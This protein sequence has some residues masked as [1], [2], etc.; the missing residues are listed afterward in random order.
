MRRWYVTLLLLSWWCFDNQIAAFAPLAPLRVIRRSSVPRRSSES[1]ATP[2]SPSEEWNVR[3]VYDDIHKLRQRIAQDRA[4]DNLREIERLELL[5]NFAANRRPLFS[6][7]RRFIL[8]PILAAV[9]MTGLSMQSTEFARLHRLVRSVFRVEFWMVVVAAPIALSRVEN[10]TPM[11]SFNST[12]TGEEVDAS[13]QLRQAQLLYST[14]INVDE[15][16]E[17]SITETC[18]CLVEYWASAVAG[19]A[20]MATTM[21][22]TQTGQVFS[23]LW[24]C[25]RLVTRLGAIASLHQYPKLLYDMRRHPRPHNK[26]ECLVKEASSIMLRLAVVGLTFDLSEIM[27]RTL[28]RIVILAVSLGLLA[29]SDLSMIVAVSSASTL[30]GV[31]ATATAKLLGWAPYIISG[32]FLWSLPRSLILRGFLPLSVASLAPIV[33]MVAVLRLLRIEH[34]HDLSLAN[35]SSRLIL[36]NKEALKKRMKWRYRLVW[37]D[38]TRRLWTALSEFVDNAVFRFLFEGG[39][40]DKILNA[41][42]QQLKRENQDMYDKVQ[43]LDQ[44]DKSVLESSKWKQSS[45]DK[46]A[47]EHQADYETG[48]F[49]DPLGV[50]IQQTFDIGLGF[51]DSHMD[52]LPK[53]EHPSARRLQSRAAKSAIRRLQDIYDETKAI[54]FD[55]ITDF[56]EREAAKANIRH[57]EE[58]ER[59]YLAK[60]LSE[61]IPWE[62]EGPYD[63]PAANVNLPKKMSLR[64]MLRAVFGGPTTYDVVPTVPPPPPPPPPG[65]DNISWDGSSY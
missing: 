37:R 6:T 60:E 24:P 27:L 11:R 7:A 22:L 26:L 23:R 64:K 31:L 38:P 44:L 40:Q 49:R 33:H 36:Q 45:M 35:S 2:A 48:V 29:L 12:S 1:A 21:F 61:L 41:S 3:N 54:D 5:D 8:Y 19:T 58:A 4:E 20:L 65:T 47:E 15:K 56:Q 9:T 57:R 46:L 42:R 17:T 10:S 18:A 34:N 62:D 53:G 43:E 13:P 50:A 32:R 52:P 28:P 30:K 55:A 16:E 14:M 25:V 39:V 63:D 59:E 51:A